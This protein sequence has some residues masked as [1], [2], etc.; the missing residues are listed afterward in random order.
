M[1]N[2]NVEIKEQ[3]DFF[4]ELIKGNKIVVNNPIYLK[5]KKNH[6]FSV[7]GTSDVTHESIEDEI[8]IMIEKSR[9][10]KQ[11]GIK[12]RCKSLS[13]VPFIRFDSDGPA[14]RNDDPRKSIKENKIETPH[15]NTFNNIGQEY[16]YKT[17]QLL[18]EKE[19]V[20]IENDLNFGLAHFCH[21]TNTSLQDGTFPEA[22]ELSPEL[23]F[24][25]LPTINF[26]DM[27]FE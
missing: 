3:F 20:A 4:L 18:D 16:A 24:V 26:T 21:E 22:I 2:I 1:L 11:Y 14:H 9:R 13:S 8:L 5:P 27:N 10:N 15:F 7:Y 12:L 6:N 17:T 23:A 25:D 19:S